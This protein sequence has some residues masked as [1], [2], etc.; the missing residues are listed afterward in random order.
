MFYKNGVFIIVR[1]DCLKKSRKVVLKLKNLRQIR[2]NLGQLS[3][4]LL[5]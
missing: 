2:P 4:V 3:G 1:S 5:A